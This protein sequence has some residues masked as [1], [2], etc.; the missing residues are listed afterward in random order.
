M[1]LICTA[2]GENGE[3]NLKYIKGFQKVRE[4]STRSLRSRSFFLLVPHRP[5]TTLLTSHHGPLDSSVRDKLDDAHV[6]AD[7]LARLLVVYPWTERYFS[8]FGNPSDAA[9]IAGNGKV[10]AHGKKILAA[11][12]N[13]IQHLDD[14]KGFLAK[15]S[16]SEA[17]DLRVDPGNFQYRSK[18]LSRYFGG[19]GFDSTET[20]GDRCCFQAGSRLHPLNPGCLG[21]VPQRPC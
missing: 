11:L 13:S 9:A 17:N 12:G 16:K 8:S 14:V 20:T 6:G 15:L 5:P 1:T 21:E 2:T 3:I 10:Q 18:Y 19:K 7:A 4:E